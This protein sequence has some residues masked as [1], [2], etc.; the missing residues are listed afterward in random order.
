[1]GRGYNYAT[2]LEGALKAKDYDDRDG[3]YDDGDVDDLRQ[4]G[5]RLADD[6]LYDARTGQRADLHA[7][8]RNSGVL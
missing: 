4:T 6:C 8:R 3:D 7:Q 5:Q 1:M 2:C